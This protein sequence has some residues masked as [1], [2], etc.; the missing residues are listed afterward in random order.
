MRVEVRDTGAGIAADALADIF[1]HYERTERVTTPH[2]GG[3]G[4]LGLA[5]ARRIVRLHGSELQVESVVGQGTQVSFD[6]PLA[7]RNAAAAPGAPQPATAQDVPPDPQA[8]IERLRR[9]LALSESNRATERTLA[10]AAQRGVEQRYLLALRGAQ[11]G[12]WEWNLGTG[13][14]LKRCVSC[15]KTAA[16]AT[17]CRARWRCATTPACPAA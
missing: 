5:I 17:C 16:C 10:Q 13:S 1:A 11:D 8:Q 7:A 3:E 12:L 2:S 6:L 9:L 15:T 14:V 4:G